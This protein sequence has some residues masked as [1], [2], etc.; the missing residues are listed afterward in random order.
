MFRTKEINKVGIYEFTFVI[1]GEYKPIHVDDFI[2][3]YPNSGKP[4]FSKANNEGEI[5]VE[6]LE[7]AWA[8]L[9][10]SYSII[11]GGCSE[12]V[13]SRLTQKP[14]LT[15]FHADTDKNAFWSHIKDG[16]K[17]VYIMSAATNNELSEGQLN[18][19]H[20]HHMYSVLEAFNEKDKNGN[21]IKL[22]KCR[23]PWGHGEW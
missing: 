3:C 8:K 13:Y 12:E 4:C 14:S 7:K 2:P 11:I 1:N 17:R 18:G 6:L 5:W 9:H 23:N 20:D 15:L 21:D 16:S 10:G 22:I 19:L